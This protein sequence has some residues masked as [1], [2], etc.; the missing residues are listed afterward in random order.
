MGQNVLIKGCVFDTVVADG[1]TVDVIETPFGLRS[2]AF[3]PARGF[4]LNG[5]RLAI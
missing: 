5:E 4:I 1:K 3:D 2:I